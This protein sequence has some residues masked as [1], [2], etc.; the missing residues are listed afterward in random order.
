MPITSITSIT[1]HDFGF[2]EAIWDAFPEYAYGDGRLAEI[3][4]TSQVP[5]VILGVVL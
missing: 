3:G 1:L 4:R 5:G 2:V